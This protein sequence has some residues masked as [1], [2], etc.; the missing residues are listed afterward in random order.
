MTAGRATL[1]DPATLAFDRSGMLRIVSGL[2]TQ[3]AE[4]Y[5]AGRSL[6]GLPEP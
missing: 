6:P 2:G 1:D 3:L 4:G 5:A